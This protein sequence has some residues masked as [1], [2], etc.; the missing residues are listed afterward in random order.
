MHYSKKLI[1]LWVMFYLPYHAH[2]Q[3]LEY[4]DVRLNITEKVGTQTQ[5]LSNADL[6]ISDIGSVATD[7][8]GNYSFKYPVNGQ[9]DPKLSVELL[10]GQHKLLQPLDGNICLNPTESE[11]VIDLVVV[12]MAEESEAF[13]KRIS[14][15]EQKI[16]GLR[17]QNKLTQQQLNALNATLLDT[18]LHYESI[19]ARLTSKVEVLQDLTEE[20]RQAL[21]AQQNEIDALN[22]RVDVLTQELTA[23]LEEKYLRQN[24]Y[25]KDV[26]A[27]LTQFLRSAKDIR[28]HLPHIKT[29]YNSP[30]GFQGMDRDCRLYEEAFVELDDRQQEYLE[31]IDHYWQNA[32]INKDLEEVFDL[33]IKGLHL[34][35]VRPLV[36]DIFN[37]VRKQKPGK[38]QKMANNSQETLA[39]NIH[40]LEQK[41]NRILVKLRNN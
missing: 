17:Q 20:Q 12:N 4:I 32:T 35:Q 18:I 3:I 16:S 33:L 8:Q 23:A 29:Y 14:G 10:S 1:L 21:E 28:D 7:E 19:K 27:N 2:S 26:S 36:N 41:I 40:S 34:S 11:M 37:E 30:G 13:K 15:L 25:F 5:P 31:G 22:A 24:Q 9:T 38:A 39:V 6:K